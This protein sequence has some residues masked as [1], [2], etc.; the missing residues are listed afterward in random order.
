MLTM[1]TSEF[2][3]LRSAELNAGVGYVCALPQSDSWSTEW[4]S[5]WVAWCANTN[6]SDWRGQGWGW[7]SGCY[8]GQR[9]GTKLRCPQGAIKALACRLPE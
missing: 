2:R 8:Y 3:L 6:Q 5:A 7:S 1:N 9:I 4:S